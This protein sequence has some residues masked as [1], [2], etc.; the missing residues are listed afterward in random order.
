MTSESTCI[1]APDT[2]AV[3]S[4]ELTGLSGDSEAP[5][6]RQ[7]APRRRPMSLAWISDALLEE[8]IEAWSEA[9]GRRISEEEAVEILTNIKQLGEVLLEAWREADRK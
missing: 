1:L 9:Y 6:E 7:E 4:P 8:T 2:N 3:S 5:V